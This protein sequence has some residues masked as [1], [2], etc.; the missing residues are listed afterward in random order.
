MKKI[1]EELA[2]KNAQMLAKKAARKESA[3]KLKGTQVP[4]FAYEDINGNIVKSKAFKGK[5]VYI[6]VW[7]TW[8]APCRQQIPFLKEIQNKYK[9]KKIAFVSI[10]IDKRKDIDKWKETVSKES[11]GGI[12][13][14][15]DKDWD[16]EFIKALGIS[17]IPRFILIGPDG[18]IID[19]DAKRPSDPALQAELD[20]LLK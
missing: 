2:E 4:K 20:T 17:S 7:A 1:G 5:Y 9:T 16:S 15:A 3:E 14:F 6:D 19:A 10:S 13:L 11:L 12:L 18:K 8:C